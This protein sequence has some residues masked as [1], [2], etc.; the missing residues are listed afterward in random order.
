MMTETG[1]YFTKDLQNAWNEGREAAIRG[2]DLG[3]CPYEGS[4]LASLVR[5][6]AWYEGHTRGD[7]EVNS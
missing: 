2:K 7:E 5:K 1:G 6:Q 4:D 3:E